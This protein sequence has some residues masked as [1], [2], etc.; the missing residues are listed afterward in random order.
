M[1]SAQRNGLHTVRHLG[2]E[3]SDQ[4]RCIFGPARLYVC[5]LWCLTGRCWEG[6]ELNWCNVLSTARHS[7]RWHPAVTA[8]TVS[9]LAEFHSRQASENTAAA[10]SAVELLHFTE[11]PSSQKKKKPGGASQG[12]SDAAAKLF[13]VIVVYRQR[14]KKKNIHH[15][16]RYRVS[17]TEPAPSTAAPWRWWCS[18]RLHY[19]Q[20]S[21]S[22]TVRQPSEVDIHLHYAHNGC[23]VL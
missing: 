13:A 15:Q 22:Q 2:S 4:L 10:P 7:S 9:D 3:A 11:K 21:S 23:Q 19:C 5:V 14:G 18:A 1:H 16:Q 12:L 6:C 8:E 20:G 17:E